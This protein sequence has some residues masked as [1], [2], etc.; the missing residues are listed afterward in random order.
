MAKPA[1]LV[2]AESQIGYTETG[3]NQTK[4]GRHYKLNGNP[5][6]AMFVS[7]CCLKAEKP[8]PSMQPG[9]PDGYAA[10]VYGMQW[11]KAHGLWRPSWE[12]EPGDAI[13]YGWDGPYSSAAR[14]HTGLIVHGGPQGSTGAT[15][16]GNRDNQVGRWTFTVGDRT[17]LGTIAL[18]KLLTPAKIVIAPAKAEPQA[19]PEPGATNTGPLAHSTAAEAADLTGRLND[20]ADRHKRTEGDGSRKLLRRLRRAIRRAL[21][22]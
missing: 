3:V 1:W 6:C 4:Y 8:L 22:Q 17:V 16:E 20:R 21:R 9:M 12:A 11:A 19:R 18:S 5:W 7:W 2:K 14:M 13:V 10:V 15:V